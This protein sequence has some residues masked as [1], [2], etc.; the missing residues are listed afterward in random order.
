MT[1]WAKGLWCNIMLPVSFLAKVM[2]ITSSGALS[3]GPL[4]VSV[5]R[6]GMSEGARAGLLASLG[7]MAAEFPLVLLIGLGA[8]AFLMDNLVIFLAGIIGG[9]FILVFGALTIRDALR[10]AKPPTNGRSIEEKRIIESSFIIGFNLSAFNPFFIVWWIGIGAALAIE[11]YNYAS[12]LGIVV[13]YIAH[14]WVDFAWLMAIAYLA[15]TGTKFMESRG[16]RI[17]LLVLG[18]ILIYFGVVMLA[19]YI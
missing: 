15:E 19:S 12:Y 13:M 7:H 1:T 16:Y 4:T 2:I 9:V 3:P 14:V 17:F 18:L 10:V 5:M 8:A 11:A 6:K